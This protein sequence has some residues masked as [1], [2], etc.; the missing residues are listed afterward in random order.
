MNVVE[1]ELAPASRA[2]LV[3]AML[4]G[5][6]SAAAHLKARNLGEHDDSNLITQVVKDTAKAAA[7]SGV[8]TLV[9]SKMSGQPVLSMLTIVSAGVAGIYFLDHYSES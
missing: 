3:G 5:A 6:A 8:T 2:M 4:G 7:I 9:A 1:G